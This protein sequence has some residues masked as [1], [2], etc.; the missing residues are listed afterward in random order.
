MPGN[1]LQ[2]FFSWWLERM[3]FT[4]WMYYL[5]QVV[6]VSAIYLSTYLSTYLLSLMCITLN[7]KW[8]LKYT[9]IV[10]I[11][12]WI[13]LAQASSYKKKNVKGMKFCSFSGNE[14]LLRGNTFCVFHL[15]RDKNCVNDDGDDYMSIIL[16]IHSL[17]GFP[18]LPVDSVFSMQ[19]WV[20]LKCILSI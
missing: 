15:I 3:G 8:C 19:C 20:L 13:L 17:P 4:V 18:A 9:Y 6:V 10:T 7:S 14:F 1:N 16:H 2:Q 5:L 12:L 11:Y